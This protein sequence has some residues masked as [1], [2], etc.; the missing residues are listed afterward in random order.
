MSCRECS[1][2]PSLRQAWGCDSPSQYVVWED[3]EDIFYSCPM[4]FVSEQSNDFFEEYAYYNTF[5]GA[6][7]AIDDVVPGWIEAMAYYR[8]KL[9]FYE[10]QVNDRGSVKT[11]KGLSVLR[12]SFR[13]QDRGG[14]QF[15]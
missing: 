14:N 5:T 6:A 12:D 10:S 4:L 2:D 1:L 8:T 7:P 3:D 9:A 13:K 11:D 15:G